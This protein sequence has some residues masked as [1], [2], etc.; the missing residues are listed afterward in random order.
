MENCYIISENSHFDFFLSSFTSIF[1]FASDFISFIKFQI[2]K[3]VVLI[4]FVFATSTLSTLASVEKEAMGGVNIYLSCSRT[5]EVPLGRPINRAPMRLPTVELLG[6]NLSI[7]DCLVGY[8]ILIKSESGEVVFST[9]VASTVVVIPNIPSGSYMIEFIGE[10]YS[11][12]GLF[13]VE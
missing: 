12:F 11:F 1:N 4:L 8:E 9:L 6:N 10:N 5:H 13:T 2:M 7:P 3:K